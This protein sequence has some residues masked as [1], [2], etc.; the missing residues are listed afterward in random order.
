[1]NQGFRQRVIGSLVLL[2]LA[3]ILAPVLF[4][5]SGGPTVDETSRIPEPPALSEVPFPEPERPADIPE[6]SEP[7]PFPAPEPRVPA[8]S[9]G[10]GSQVSSREN[11]AETTEPAPE[12]TT[13]EPSTPSEPAAAEP[14]EGDPWVIQVGS[15]SERA[16]AE[17][18]LQRLVDDGFRAY[19]RTQHRNGRD[20]HLIFVGPLPSRAEAD[21]VKADIER[22][23]R[24]DV[25]V[26]RLAH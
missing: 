8:E 17:S 9:N 16:G 25:L 10:S 4:D 2:A 5:F 7:E 3:V 15:F 21:R 23:Y 6:P 19:H 26:R 20:L 18:L 12:P 11:R 22:Q 24:L 1:M 13:G 14:I